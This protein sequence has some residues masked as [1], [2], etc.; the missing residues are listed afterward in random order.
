MIDIVF[1]TFFQFIENCCNF[2]L[3]IGKKEIT[4]AVNVSRKFFKFILPGDKQNKN[5]NKIDDTISNVDFN[6]R[7]ADS[8]KIFKEMELLISETDTSDRIRVFTT[9]F[10]KILDNYI[11]IHYFKNLFQS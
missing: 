3:F 11:F 2:F 8:K 5:E 7:Y 1:D 9:Y 6:N 10:I 4:S